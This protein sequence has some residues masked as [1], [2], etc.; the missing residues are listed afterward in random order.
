M[1]TYYGYAEREA[2]DNIDWSVIGSDITKML[3][4]EAT[5]RET[6]KK[7]LD[8]ASRKYGETLSNSPMGESEDANN[9]SIDLADNASKMRLM[10]DR[11]LKTGQL[12]LKDYLVGRE[13]LKSDTQT[14]YTAL[15]D[16]QEYYGMRSKRMTDKESAAAEQ[17]LFGLSEGFGNFSKAGIYINPTNGRIS[18]GK[19]ERVQGKDGN[20]VYKMSESP[21]DYFTVNELRNYITKDINRFDAT[22]AVNSIAQSVG[23][24]IQQRYDY[25]ASTRSFI[26]KAIQDPT[27]E[28]FQELVNDGTLTQTEV[29]D[30][31]KTFENQIDLELDS[32]FSNQFDLSSIL[33]DSIGVDANG[34]SYD[35]TFNPDDTKGKNN[36]IL[37]T[38]DPNSKFIGFDFESKEGKEQVSHARNVLKERIKLRLGKSV[39]ETGKE[40]SRESAANK[41]LRIDQGKAEAQIDNVLTDWIIGAMGSSDKATSEASYNNVISLYNKLNENKDKQILRIDKVGD[42]NN[43]TIQVIFSDKKTL[44]PI[45]LNDREAYIRAIKGLFPDQFNASGFDDDEIT[46]KGLSKWKASS[47]GDLFNTNTVDVGVDIGA[48]SPSSLIAKVK[49]EDDGSYTN[50]TF[51]QEYKKVGDNKAFGSGENQKLISK[52][53]TISTNQIAAFNE[54]RRK[55]GYKPITIKTS[56]TGSNLAV[57]NPKN[58]ARIDIKYYDADPMS[59]AYEALMSNVLNYQDGVIDDNNIEGAYKS[60]LETYLSAIDKALIMDDATMEKGIVLGGKSY[61]YSDMVVTDQAGNKTYTPVFDSLVN[62]AKKLKQGKSTQGTATTQST[63]SGGTALK[64]TPLSN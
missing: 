62:M 25:D 3:Q 41:K 48:T 11:L 37:M 56:K 20:Y 63:T 35:F 19:K 21:G 60:F 54:K 31:K 17:Y 46:K 24:I 22:A 6:L 33:T 64:K 57:E 18:L 59:D 7:D 2:E 43:P 50:I 44:D 5:R 51:E 15:K 30:I 4:D 40:K 23:G 26:T 52:L 32:V 8:D 10:N 16:F 38:K 36:I 1:S 42:V 27:G 58:A 34:E 49:K 61:S 28:L 13:N 47:S 45:K 12:K 9:L 29:D 14:L 55:S 53:N 39:Q